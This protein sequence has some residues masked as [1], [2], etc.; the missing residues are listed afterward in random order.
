[1]LY[2]S[3]YDLSRSQCDIKWLLFT[4][5]QALPKHCL[6]GK[7]HLSRV[8]EKAFFAT[9]IL[10]QCELRK[11]FYSQIK[12]ERGRESKRVSIKLKVDH[13]KHY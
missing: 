5:F 1:M 13:R 6:E 4:D 7:E 2:I 11:Q 9:G 12:L 10:L 3:K 8:R